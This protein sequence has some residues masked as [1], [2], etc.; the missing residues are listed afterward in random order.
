VTPARK[1]AVQMLLALVLAVVALATVVGRSPP[2][3]IMGPRITILYIHVGSAWSAYLAYAAT[4]IGAIGYLR[5][6]R[7]TF[8]HLAV[9]G[10]ETGLVLTT[11]TLVTGS[12]WA[13]ATQGWW[14][15]WEPRLTITLMLWFLYAAYMILRQYTSGEGQA[16]LSAVL[17][18]AGIPAM[19]LNHFATSLYRSFHPAPIVLRWGGPAVGDPMYLWGIGVGVGALTLVFAALLAARWR[20]E[21]RRDEVR[22]LRASLD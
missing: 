11:V 3:R 13:R 1:S 5:R 12:L 6:R 20:L 21:E 2:E 7:R 14:W 4:A 18:I 8:D 22:Q 9:A 19:V 16:R 17:A 10:A 15:L